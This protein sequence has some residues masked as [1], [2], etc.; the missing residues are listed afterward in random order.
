MVN[1]S[2]RPTVIESP[3]KMWA[4]LLHFFLLILKIEHGELSFLNYLLLWKNRMTGT[5]EA[6]QDIQLYKAA[7]RQL[8]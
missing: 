8:R 4:V 2:K 6:E 5:L 1:G 3:L 7:Q